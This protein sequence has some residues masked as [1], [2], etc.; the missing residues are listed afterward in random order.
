M[1][2]GQDVILDASFL[3]RKERHRAQ[4]LA[5]QFGA[6][7]VLVDTSA[8]NDELVRRLQLRKRSAT[9]ASEA[10]IVVLQYQYNSADSLD[11]EECQRTVVV[12]TD[13]NIDFDNVIERVK[14]HRVLQGANP[15]AKT[16][17][18]SLDSSLSPQ[19]IL[20]SHA[21]HDFT[22]L[23]QNFSASSCRRRQNH[24]HQRLSITRRAS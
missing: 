6:T 24:Q 9:D 23:R 22:K 15:K 14:A 7:F 12:L 3:R 20:P 4:A 18:V 16:C 11:A 2:F 8:N 19:A 13:A 1:R 5:D 21:T 17:Q 10:D